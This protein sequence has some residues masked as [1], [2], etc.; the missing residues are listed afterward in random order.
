MDRPLLAVKPDHVP[1][2][3][4]IDFDMYS[5]P[6]VEADFHAAWGR[7][8]DE[9]VPEMV[10]TPRNGGHWI[11]TRGALIGRLYAD[12]ENFSNRVIVVPKWAGETHAL[13]PTTLDPPVH[14]PFRALLNSSLAPKAIKGLEETI[15]E[16]AVELIESFRGDGQC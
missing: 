8:L 10:W 11:A 15:R 6:D 16:T 7:L 12:Y 5:P 9:A 3:H 2:D 1:D 14:R 13:L 4:V